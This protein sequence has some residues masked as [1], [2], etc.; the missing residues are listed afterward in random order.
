MS[1]AGESHIV[2][3][4]LSAILRRFEPTHPRGSYGTASNEM[5]FGLD[6]HVVHDPGLNLLDECVHA[7]RSE[8]CERHPHRGQRWGHELR[9]RGIGLSDDRELVGHTESTLPGETENPDGLADGVC[10]ER[11]HIGPAL[12][13]FTSCLGAAALGEVTR[14][15]LGALQPVLGC[16]RP[17]DGHAPAGRIEVRRSAE[18]DDAGMAGRDEMVENELD[19]TRVVHEYVPATARKPAVDEDVR[20]WA[21]LELGEQGVVGARGRDEETVD[22]SLEHEPGEDLA[23]FLLLEVLGQDDGEAPFHRSPERAAHELRVD[24]AS[25]GRDE[26]AHCTRSRPAQAARRSMRTVAKVAGRCKHP[27]AQLHADAESGIAVQDAGSD[28]LRRLGGGCHVGERGA[29]SR[30]TGTLRAHLSTVNDVRMSD[31]GPARA[32]SHARARHEITVTDPALDSV[33]AVGYFPHKIDYLPGPHPQSQS[34]FMNPSPELELT[35]HIDRSLCTARGGS[36]LLST[37]S[38]ILLMERTAV[39]AVEPLLAANETTVGTDVRASHRAPTPEGSELRVKVT[40]VKRE[41]RYFTLSI[42]AFDE[43][44]LVGVADHQRAVVDTEKYAAR[45]QA[46]LAKLEHLGHPDAASQP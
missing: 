9:Q 36:Y 46:K 37:P 16:E 10:E 39:R 33:T 8:F 18:V 25:E 13:C 7:G 27:L 22:P 23:R 45:I 41:G 40:I 44:E 14:Y 4:L 20:Q 32:P 42:E 19:S 26:Q 34:R 6:E 43:L 2:G 17:K 21:L 5:R 1:V 15:D 12:K 38:L 24:R 30:P 11:C 31:N 35:W 29:Y 28:W 3:V